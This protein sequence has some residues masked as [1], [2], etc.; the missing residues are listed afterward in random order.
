[1]TEA[2]WGLELGSYAMIAGLGAWLL[3]RKGAA[4][5]QR[6]PVRL[7]NLRPAGS[8]MLLFEAPS[9]SRGSAPSRFQS[10]GF[11]RLDD[12]RGEAGCD[13]ASPHL[14]PPS[15]GPASL[16]TDAMTVLAIGLRPCSGAIVVL[17]FA[18]LNGL[19][20]GGG[21][22]VGA[23]ALGTAI[24]VSALAALAVGSKRLAL[25]LG[26]GGRTLRLVLETAGAA[27]LL[28]FGA[29]LFLASL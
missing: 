11:L 19:Y 26:G 5:A 8:G 2:A 7:T 28:A 29:G 24:T 10:S 22:A 3:L 18:L 15:T 9:S 21:L 25:G 1:M 17:T 23:M 27:L 12:C 4:L 13:C 14:P 16:R 6:L 20:L